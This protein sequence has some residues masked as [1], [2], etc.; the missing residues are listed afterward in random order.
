MSSNNLSNNISDLNPKVRFNDN[1]NDSNININDN[2]DNNNTSES[3]TLDNDSL[4]E[5]ALVLLN[6]INNEPKTYKQAI[7]SLNKQEWL[8]AINNEIKELESQNT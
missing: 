5:L 8:N 3:N 4:D 7:N 1:I 2:N 6:N